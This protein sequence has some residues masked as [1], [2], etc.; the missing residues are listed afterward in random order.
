MTQKTKAITYC[1]IILL[2]VFAVSFLNIN[3][4]PQMPHRFWGSV[5]IGGAPAPDGTLI[6]AVI[7]SVT[8]K[9]TTTS[10]GNYDLQV[11]ADDPETPAIEGGRNGDL[12]H[13]YVAKTYATNHTFT[14]GEI[15][16]LNLSIA[17][18]TAYADFTSDVTNGTEPLTVKFIDQSKFFD[19]IT[20]YTWNFGDGNTTITTNA[21]IT[22]I[23]IQ[24]GTYTVSLTVNGTKAGENVTSTTT[25]PNY[26]TVYDS[27]PT[28]DFY[29][30]PTSGMAPLI[31][32]FHDNSTSYDGIISWFWNFGDGTNSTQ[33]NPTHN[34][35][36]PGVYTV[37]LTVTEQDGDNSTKTKQNYI[38]VQPT[39]PTPPTIEILNPT[40]ANPV[41]IKPGQ[42]FE[43][44]LKY[45][46]LNPLNGTIKIYNATYTVLQEA[47]Q[48]A[49][50]PGT[51]I[52]LTAPITIPESA[53][54]GK[55]SLSITMFNIYNLSATVTQTD[56]I[57][58]DSTSPTISSPY[59]TPPGATVQPNVIV[60][61]DV[62]QNITVRVN[63]TD[64]LSTIKEVTLTYNISATGWA[65]ITMQKT[66][67]NEYMATIPSSNLPVCTTIVYYIRAT[68][69]ADNTAQT[70]TAGS[71]FKFH[72]IPEFNV[73]ATLITLLT[74]AAVTAAM[75]REEQKFLR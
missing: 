45:T 22:H 24:N 16:Q 36:E 41:Y 60:S 73:L 39:T 44:R 55:Y 12:I 14:I 32:S 21:N 57:I 48:T 27:K 10:N 53:P 47:N 72:I 9:S 42:A 31:V 38:T 54:D 35:T 67:G 50:T 15:T 2:L 71:Y 37:S 26:I 40:T 4:V 43:L 64:I 46:E 56:A 25:K 5:T 65:N 20:A 17:V 30:T 69:N 33:Q 11:P 74:L 66:V 61:V 49:I 8:F 75:K 28:A 13:F 70:P 68:D 34:Y 52:T 6:E 3:A 51:G 7:N 62:G 59:Q 29:A 19:T 23:Y 1:I 58:I 63:V 18:P